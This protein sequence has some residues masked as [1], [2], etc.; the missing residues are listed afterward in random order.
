MRNILPILLAFSL[1]GCVTPRPPVESVADAIVVTA[2][3]IESVAQ[4]VKTL[5][6]NLEPGG[7]CADGAAIS[8][9]T[10]AML[11]IRLQTAQ[12]ALVAANRL[13]A[14][15]QSVD[16]SDKLAVADAIIRALQAELARRAP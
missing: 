13:L 1:L 8:T 16:A 6:G 14:A 5:C 11:K 9:E 10:K 15:G 12:D 3:D 7:P 2:A 4:T